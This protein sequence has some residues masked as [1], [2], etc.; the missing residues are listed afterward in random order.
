MA[1]LRNDVFD[2]T[3]EFTLKRREK[4]NTADASTDVATTEDDMEDVTIKGAYVIIHNGH[5][6]D[7][8]RRSLEQ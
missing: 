3:M 2:E 8:R 6:R 5:L 1:D 7:G 4:D